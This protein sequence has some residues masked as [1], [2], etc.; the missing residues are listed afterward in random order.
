MRVL[1]SSFQG[2][3]FLSVSRTANRVAHSV[4]KEAL[5]LCSELNFDVIPGFLAA[6][7]QSERLQFYE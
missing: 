1:A 2:F 6:L 4:A 7:V 5:K 3:K